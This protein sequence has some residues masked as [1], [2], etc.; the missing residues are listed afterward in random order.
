MSVLTKNKNF[1]TLTAGQL[2]STIGNNLFSLALPWYVFVRTGS[3]VDLAWAGIAMTLPSLLG[4]VSGVFVDRWN[5]RFTMAASDTLRAILCAVLTVAVLLHQPLWVILVV[6]LVLEAIGKFFDPAAA[7]L[8]PQIVAKDELPS[9]SGIQQSSNATAQ[10]VGTLSGG[11]LL[12][13]L[14]PALLFASD[15]ASFLVS[16]TSV[17]LIRIREVLPGRAPASAGIA[18]ADGAGGSSGTGGAGADGR[19]VSATDDGG[20]SRSDSTASAPAGSASSAMS[21]FV[22]EWR[23]GFQLLRKSKFLQ[24]LVLLSVCAN[25][26]LSP[27]DLGLTAWVKGPMHGNALLLSLINAF[28]FCGIIGGGFLVGTVSRR[29][30]LRSILIVGMVFIGVIFSGIGFWANFA[31]DA[32]LMVCGGL[33]LGIINGASG[34]LMLQKIP[35]HLRGRTMGTTFALSTMAMPLGMVLFGALVAHV[36]LSVVFAVCGALC[37]MTGMILMLPVRD[38]LDEVFSSVTPQGVGAEGF[39]AAQ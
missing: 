37:A 13:A 23:E 16:A 18:A 12:T 24:L 26:A 21:R 25:F 5:K 1:A 27:V 28:F 15:G 20:A 33:G 9:A 30:S 31:W 35:A 19:A 6:V 4:F 32:S 7:S 14:G 36:P 3:K 2:I 38:D 11:A 34:A 29:V 17:L 10:L 22:A 8:L 39:G